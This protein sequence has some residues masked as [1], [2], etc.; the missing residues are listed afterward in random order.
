ML[1]K[2]AVT[3]KII[4]AIMNAPTNIQ[5]AFAFALYI[6]PS[7][8]FFL[9]SP[10]CKDVRTGLKI[11]FQKRDLAKNSKVSDIIFTFYARIKYF[12]KVALPIASIIPSRLFSTAN[13]RR[14]R[15]SLRFVAVAPVI[16]SSNLCLSPGS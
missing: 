8:L 4:I 5:I 14:S 2:T 7:A 10:L 15:K 9:W 1:A 3:G 13:C 6:F 16:M 12:S 11:I